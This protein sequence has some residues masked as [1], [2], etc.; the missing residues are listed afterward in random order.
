MPAHIQM[1][2]PLRMGAGHQPLLQPGQWFGSYLLATTDG[3][4]VDGD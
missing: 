4:G 3:E 2:D 1:I